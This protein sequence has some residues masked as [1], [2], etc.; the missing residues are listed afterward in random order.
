MRVLSELD[1]DVIG[2]QEVW[3]TDDENQAALLA[4]ELGY[5]F[6]FVP[7]PAPEK[8]QRRIDDNTVGIGN[9]VL[10]RWPILSTASVCLPAGDAEDEGRIALHVTI[11]SPHGR[12]PFMTTQLNSAWGHN[13][14]RRNQLRSACDLVCSQPVER[15]P[16]VLCGD[17]NAMDDYDEIRALAGKSAPLVADL[18]LLDAW[19]FVGHDRPGYT[20]DRTNP[21]VERS[22]EPSARIDYV[23]I[24]IAQAGGAGKAVDAGLFGCTPLDGIWPSDHFGVWTDI[25]IPE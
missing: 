8:W 6:A 21:H 16:P 23:F 9:A 7:S 11:D 14:I 3:C 19:K 18:V 24:G 20:W 15:F 10:S 5:E 25:H 17:F 4:A 13:E 1:A 22:H 2:L 12:V